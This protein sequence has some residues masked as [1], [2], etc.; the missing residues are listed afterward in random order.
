MVSWLLALTLIGTLLGG[1][2]PVFPFTT[3]EQIIN[4]GPPGWPLNSARIVPC[5]QASILMGEF[6]S[7]DNTQGWVIYLPFYEE[8]RTKPHPFVGSHYVRA[9]SAPGPDWLA[10]GWINP[11][12]RIVIQS[13]EQF[14]LLRHG[15]GPCRHLFS[16][17]ET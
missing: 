2:A 10:F 11:D 8:Q 16:G 17:V 1:S 5:P 13:V 6:H 12:G 3:F 4:Q 14:D 7:E 15:E 9:S